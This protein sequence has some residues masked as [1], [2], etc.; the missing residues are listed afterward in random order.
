MQLELRCN[1]MKLDDKR[2]FLFALSKE[3]LYALQAWDEHYRREGSRIY[4]R[5]TYTPLLSCKGGQIGICAISSSL[6]LHRYAKVLLD[7]QDSYWH[8]RDKCMFGACLTAV[9]IHHQE[10]EIGNV[11]HFFPSG[12]VCIPPCSS[13]PGVISVDAHEEFDEEMEL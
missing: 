12:S 6:A 7:C 8:L 4:R 10:E 11:D 13:S 5:A 9:E 1:L 3:S 2:I